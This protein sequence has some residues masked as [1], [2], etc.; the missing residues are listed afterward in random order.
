MDEFLRQRSGNFRSG[1]RRAQRQ[2]VART[3]H[4]GEFSIREFRGSTIDQGVDKLLALER[5][6]WKVR[7][8]RKRTLYVT[9]NEQYRHFYRDVA[10]AFAATD[11][12]QV[13]VTE[14][15]G[16]PAN[17]LFSL[18]RQGMITCL[19]TYQAEELANLTSVAPLWGRFFELAI[20]RGLHQVDFNGNNS[21]LARY[22]T[23]QTRFSRLVFY[24]DALYSSVLRASADAA[25]LLARAFSRA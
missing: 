13:L 5:Q 20:A 7:D 17:A 22:A 4:L 6:S 24:N 10:S 8:A 21:Y 16:R 1:L 23:G 3:A 2:S 25:H 11:E 19:L 9:L 12:A 15:G 14:V 18:E